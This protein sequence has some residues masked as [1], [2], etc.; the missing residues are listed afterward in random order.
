MQNT[1]RAHSILKRKF[2][3][4][5]KDECKT[6]ETTNDVFFP[7]SSI[8]MALDTCDI[9]N[10]F[11]IQSI[12]IHNCMK[13]MIA[14]DVELKKTNNVQLKKEYSN[15]V[16]CNSV[17]CRE[18]GSHKFVEDERAGDLVC[19]NCGVVQNSKSLTKHQQLF[20]KDGM[21]YNSTKSDIPEWAF[22]SCKFSHGEWKNIQ[23]KN[24]IWNLNVHL[25][26]T[27]DKVETALYDSKKINVKSS[28]TCKAMSALLFQDLKES[29]LDMVKS[30][31]IEII[32]FP[33]IQVQTFGSCVKCSKQYY[34][35]KEKRFHH[36]VCSLKD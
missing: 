17:V 1:L 29:I 25:N 24:E 18:C 21:Q 15:S 16:V 20:E 13:S 32:S 7:F 36:L 26:F 14:T 27:T 5:Q 28:L 6:L 23:L 19:T 9:V 22:N 35:N 3:T 12:D 2:H 31:K 8:Q 4:L 34:S 30:G 33:K 10:K 11:N